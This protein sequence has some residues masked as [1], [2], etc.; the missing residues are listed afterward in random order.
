MFYKL[1]VLLFY[2]HLARACAAS[3]V[4]RVFS[5]AGIPGMAALK[6]AAVN[7]QLPNAAEGNVPDVAN[8]PGSR[9]SGGGGMYTGP[10]G[11]PLPHFVAA[12]E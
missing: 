9:E 5:L 2:C 7:P 6:A 1:A 4:R 12:E 3:D 8:P 10:P 11:G